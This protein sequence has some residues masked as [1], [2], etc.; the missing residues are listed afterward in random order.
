MYLQEDEL[1][2]ECLKMF[3]KSRSLSRRSI[4]LGLAIALVAVAIGV[5]GISIWCHQSAGPLPVPLGGVP[6]RP[7]IVSALDDLKTDPERFRD[8]R[9]RVVA[10]IAVEDEIQM[11]F[12]GRPSRAILWVDSPPGPRTDGVKAFWILAKSII[13]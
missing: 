12:I 2:S 8:R 3:I 1:I 9:I 5:Y 10:P 11:V 13:W 7:I 6:E 4:V